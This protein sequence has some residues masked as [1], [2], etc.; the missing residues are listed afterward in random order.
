MLSRGE[1]RARRE[2]L[3]RTWAAWL[4]TDSTGSPD[5]PDSPGAGTPSGPTQPGRLG[6]DRTLLESWR[7]SSVWVSPELRAAPVDDP[8]AVET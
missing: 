1:L 7:R 3:T 8:G 5:S 6:P 4:T 2:Q